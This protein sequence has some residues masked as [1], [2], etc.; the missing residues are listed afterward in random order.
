VADKQ[1]QIYTSGY[2]E[3]DTQ[4]RIPVSDKQPR[5]AALDKQQLILVSDKQQQIA[6]SDKQQRVHSGRYSSGYTTK[7]TQW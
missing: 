6:A 1:Q 5:I 7:Q 2:T 3:A 4:Q